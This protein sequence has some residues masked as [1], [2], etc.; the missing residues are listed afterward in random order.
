MQFAVCGACEYV[1][2]IGGILAPPTENVDELREEI[3]MKG[4]GPAV[5]PRCKLP[6]MFR[7]RREADTSTSSNTRVTQTA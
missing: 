2:W 5:C 7:M 1:A 3:V 4:K 6:V